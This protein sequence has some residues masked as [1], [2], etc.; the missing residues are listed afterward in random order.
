MFSRKEPELSSLKNMSFASL[1]PGGMPMEYDTTLSEGS[2]VSL[3]G[4]R[5]PLAPSL[6]IRSDRL[7]RPPAG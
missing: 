1:V 7:M 2:S 5:S 3:T 4:S 6:K